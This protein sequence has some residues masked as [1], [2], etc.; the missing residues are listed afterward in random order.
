MLSS[1]IKAADKAFAGVK[2]FYF[3]SRYADRRLVPG[4]SDFTFGNPHEM[5]LKGIVDALR[6]RA[7]PHDKNWFAYKTSEEE[8][9]QFLARR[10]GGWFGRSLQ[11][12]YFSY[13]DF[14]PPSS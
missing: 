5:P 4:I 3:T 11:H 6:D 14:T 13:V 9:Q 10:R 12:Q 8:P 2:D 1:R 7:V